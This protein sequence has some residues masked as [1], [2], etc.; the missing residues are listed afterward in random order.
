MSQ[1]KKQLA[2][3][4]FSPLKFLI[5]DGDLLTLEPAEVLGQMVTMG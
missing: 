5:L 3:V 2:R 4:I 1:I